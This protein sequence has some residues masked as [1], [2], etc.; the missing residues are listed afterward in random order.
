MVTRWGMSDRLGMVQLAPRENPYLPGLDGQSSARPFSEETARAV[1]AEVHR[2]I[3][4]SHEEA[5]RL[6][7]RYRQELDALANALLARETLDEQ[8]ILE[9]TGLPPAAPLEARP[10][11]DAGG[12]IS[13]RRG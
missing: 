3:G 8:E 1:D 12:E 11:S 13:G 6:L 2:I 9:V 10:R 4:E 7:T 5:R